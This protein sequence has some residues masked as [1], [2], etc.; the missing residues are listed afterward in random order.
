MGGIR[1][2]ELAA[3]GRAPRL[4]RVVAA[5]ERRVDGGEECG[6][7]E[8][9]FEPRLQQ[10][11]VLRLPQSHEHLHRKGWHMRDFIEC[12]TIHTIH[13]LKSKLFELQT[14]PKLPFK[15]K[16]KLLIHTHTH[17]HMH[18]HTHERTHTYTQQALTLKS[19]SFES[20]ASSGSCTAEE[21]SLL[22]FAHF[23]LAAKSVT[24]LT[25]FIMRDRSMEPRFSS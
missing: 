15:M 22:F 3:I 4:V 12:R 17:R 11:I 7:D 24:W 2:R 1:V 8:Q 25:R 10:L 23:F 19:K 6:P 21:V 18:T 13:T 16:Q 14:H 5:L 9:G 20:S